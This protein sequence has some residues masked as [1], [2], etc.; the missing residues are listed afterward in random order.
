MGVFTFGVAVT[1]L[2][3]RMQ[4]SGVRLC[5]CD[6]IPSELT[7]FLAE[8]GLP[9]K[10]LLPVFE[11]VGVNVPR[12]ILFLEVACLGHVFVSAHCLHMGV[13]ARTHLCMH[14]RTHV[15]ACLID[16]ALTSLVACSFTGRR[17]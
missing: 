16:S 1:V 14:K 2:A 6:D 3:M 12:D 7:T 15:H 11:E 17:T 10:V 9:D 8:R 4:S 5:S 13:R